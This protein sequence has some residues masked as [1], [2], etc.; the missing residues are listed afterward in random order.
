MSTSEARNWQQASAERTEQN[1]RQTET[2]RQVKV[3]VNKRWVTP[4]EKFLYVIFSI[5]TAGVMFYVVSFSIEMDTLNRDI[6]QLENTVEQQET[7]NGNLRYQVKEYSNPARI[8]RIAKEN[9]L[10]IQNTQVKQTA[11]ISE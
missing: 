10:K 9:G 4:G 7:I 2:K 8:L 3:D 11:I 5:A 1:H 6:Q